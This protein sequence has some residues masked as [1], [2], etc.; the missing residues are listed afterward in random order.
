MA[1]AASIAFFP[2]GNGDMTLIVLESGRKI[3][4]DTNI[5]AAA[6]N[7]DEETPDVAQAAAAR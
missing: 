1:M 4:I 6:D 7:P 3:L 5:R 2:V